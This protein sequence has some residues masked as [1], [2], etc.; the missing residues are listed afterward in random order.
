MEKDVYGGG[1]VPRLLLTVG[2]FLVAESLTY[3]ALAL[4]EPQSHVDLLDFAFVFCGAVIISVVGIVEARR[5]RPDS[6]GP[7]SLATIV[8]AI[9]LGVVLGVTAGIVAYWYLN[10]H[11]SS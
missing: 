10:L 11:L 9:L 3:T 7:H 5:E 2:F 8:V 6:V 1:Y 4:G